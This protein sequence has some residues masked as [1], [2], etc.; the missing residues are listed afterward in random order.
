MIRFILNLIRAL[1][2]I[3]LCAMIILTAYIMTYKKLYND[4]YPL[5]FGYSYFKL[6][7]D[8][9]SPDYQKNDYMFL[10]HTEEDVYSV[11]DYV[12]YLENGQNVRA[13]KVTEVNE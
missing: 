2:S 9:L 11:G 7:N 1:I 13:K 10:K 8:F 6:D 4:P 5:V 3:Y 12:V